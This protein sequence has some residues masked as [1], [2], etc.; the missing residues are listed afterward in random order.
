[1]GNTCEGDNSMTWRDNIRKAAEL[2]LDRPLR[3]EALEVIEHAIL[4]LS[5]TKECI[6][7]AKSEGE[8]L[9]EYIDPEFVALEV[10]LDELQKMKNLD[11]SDMA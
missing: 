11:Y 8:R 4:E 2:N 1:M 7:T 9:G 3:N 10:I 5:S 6:N